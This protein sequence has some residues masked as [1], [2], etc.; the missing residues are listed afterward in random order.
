MK[1]YI[2]V[3]NALCSGFS[4]RT[5]YFIS[6]NLQKTNECCCNT[7]IFINMITITIIRLHIFP[8]INVLITQTV[9]VST[10]TMR[11]A[12]SNRKS[13]HW[14]LLIYR[15]YSMNL[16]CMRKTALY[17]MLKRLNNTIDIYSEKYKDVSVPN[18]D[19]IL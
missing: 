7:H 17:C 8:Y 19:K 9:L 11:S 2:L 13:L 4:L 10:A 6:K 5:L 15:K 1:P 18:Q 14:Y 3:C 12:N 16:Y